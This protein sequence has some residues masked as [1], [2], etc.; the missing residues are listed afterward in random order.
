MVE[1]RAHSE[2]KEGVTQLTRMFNNKKD[3]STVTEDV[4]CFTIHNQVT[5]CSNYSHPRR[6]NH[7]NPVPINLSSLFFNF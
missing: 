3:I 5:H 6:R 2:N 4:T 7:M 1:Y